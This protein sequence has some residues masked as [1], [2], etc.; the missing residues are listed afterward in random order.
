MAKRIS[1]C[2]TCRAGTYVSVV[3]KGGSDLE[4]HVHSAKH[5]TTAR[6]ESSLSKVRDIIVSKIHTSVT[7][8]E[9]ILPFHTIKHHNSYI[10]MDCCTSGSRRKILPD[11]RTV[12]KIST[13]RTK[14]EAIVN[15]VIVSHSVEVALKELKEIPFLSFYL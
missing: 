8:V 6:G 12:K 13:A 2:I 3:N 11:S 5:K 10:S 9:G 4:A 15:T 1:K 7:A 14:T